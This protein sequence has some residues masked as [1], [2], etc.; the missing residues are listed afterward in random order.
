MPTPSSFVSRVQ[1]LES[2]LTTAVS[3]NSSL[4]S[5][6]DLLSLAIDAVHGSESSKAIYALYR[7]FVTIVRSGKYGFS[8]EAN[9]EGRMVRRWVWDRLNQYT[10]YLA[11]LLK[12][13]EKSLRV[14]RKSSCIKPV[15]KIMI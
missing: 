11:S 14:G 13:N 7:I 12:D 6:V 4:N 3:G 1:E 8:V 5:L 15:N 2:E 10:E 9:D